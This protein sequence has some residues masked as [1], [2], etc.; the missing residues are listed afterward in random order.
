MCGY[1]FKLRAY[2]TFLTC[3]TSARVCAR[4][5]AASVVTGDTLQVAELDRV[6]THIHTCIRRRSDPLLLLK[7]KYHVRARISLRRLYIMYNIHNIRIHD[8][9]FRINISVRPERNK[10]R[11]RVS[12]EVFFLN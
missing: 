10:N 12:R 7:I 3:F 1:F 4:I 5:F 11:G 2:I 9:V 6:Y 8:I